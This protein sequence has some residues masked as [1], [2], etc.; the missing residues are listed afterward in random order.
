MRRPGVTAHARRAY[1][2][3]APAALYRA[4]TAADTATPV[5]TPAIA[6][7][8]VP[9]ARTALATRLDR[10]VH[11]ERVADSAA[12]LSA[13]DLSSLISRLKSDAPDWI[14]DGQRRGC[15]TPAARRRDVCPRAHQRTGRHAVAPGRR[16]PPCRMGRRHSPR[17]AA[18]SGGANVYSGRRSRT[19][20]FEPL[21]RGALPLTHRHPSRSTRLYRTSTTHLMATSIAHT[22]AF[23][24][25]RRGRLGTPSPPTCTRGPIRTTIICLMCGTTWRQRS[26][27]VFKATT[28]DATRQEAEIRWGY[29]EFR[30]GDVD[31]ALTHFRS[32]GT[33]DDLFLR[34]W[35]HLF[36]GRAYDDAHRPAD[37]I[38]SYGLA[39]G[40]VPFAESATIALARHSRP[41]ITRPRPLNFSHVFWL[42]LPRSTRGPSSPVRIVARGQHA[43]RR[44]E[45]QSPS[46][47]DHPAFVLAAIVWNA[48]AFVRGQAPIFRA[49]VAAILVPVSVTNGNRPV[50]GLTT[51]DFELLDGGVVQDVAAAT[52]ESV[53]TDVTLV[54][55]TSASVKG[56]ALARFIADIQTIAESLRPND[57]VRLITF[58]T[59][60]HDAFRSAARRNTA[61]HRADYR[62]RRHVVLQRACGGAHRVSPK[63]PPPAHLRI[64]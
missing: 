53:P 31:G 7:P 37:A 2:T 14:P 8:S 33:V 38:A 34:Y 19:E 59:D 43:S 44:S 57:C 41:T 46:E 1:I 20:R 60:I 5:T 12:G 11:G 58:A 48:S 40:D 56:R 30:R 61:A 10:Y 24:V 55:D 63:R 62:W 23:L 47:A 18:A 16:R 51:S 15:W 25:T 28:R 64:Q 27:R 29:Y 17:G 45:G 49:S 22:H 21:T 4:A 36:Q 6:E 26:P 54:L 35:L 39:L 3:A 13:S 50:T 32:V 42:C 9:T 52:V